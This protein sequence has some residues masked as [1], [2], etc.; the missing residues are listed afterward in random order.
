MFRFFAKKLALRKPSPNSIPMSLP[1]CADNDFYSVYI[2][3]PDQNMK[4]ICKSES[5]HGLEGFLW[6]NDSDGAEACVL[7][8]TLEGRKWSLK[9]EH[10]F[11]GWVLEYNSALLFCLQNLLQKHRFLYSKDKL[12][13]TIFNNKKLVRSERIKVLE[14]VLEKTT[15]K[16]DYR[17]DPLYLGMELYSKRWLFHPHKESMKNHYKLIFESLVESGDLIRNDHSYELSPKALNTISDYERD[18][19]KH[20]DSQNS[21]R[22][23]RNLTKAIIVLGL[24]NLGFQAFRWAYEAKLLP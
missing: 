23:T 17:T 22:K 13:Q 11:K 2:E 16:P 1:R 20:F 5:P 15:N 10:Y 24:L 9:I 7:K 6:I 12:A 8:S 21:A 18:E 4:L 19:Q 14:Y 3:I